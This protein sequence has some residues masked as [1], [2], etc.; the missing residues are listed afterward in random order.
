[1]ELLPVFNSI[2]RNI[3]IN[4]LKRKIRDRRL[5][6][7]LSKMYKVR[8]LTIFGFVKEFEGIFQDNVLSPILS[9]IYFNELDWFITNKIIHRYNK[10]LK[11]RIN[12]DYT[13][14]ITLTTQEKKLS[15]FERTR[16][17]AF[18]RRE[19]HKKGLRYKLIDDSFIR[20]KF[21]RYAD[22]LLVGIRGPK[23]LALTIKKTIRF[24]LKSELQLSINENNL[25]L[26]DSYATKI[27]FLG[28]TIHNI[29]TKI[30]T[31]RN[32][33]EL[34][35]IKRSRSRVLTRINVFNIRRE[36]LFRERILLNLR[37]NY[38]VAQDCGNLKRYEMELLAGFSIFLPKDLVKLTDR[39]LYRMMIQKFLK[40]T[41][42]QNN[43]KLQKFLKLW[44]NELKG[45][46]D[47][48][49]GMSSLVKKKELICLT[50]KVFVERMA[51]FLTKH[52]F[53][54]KVIK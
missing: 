36:K 41:N 28:M 15:S 29:V 6:D 34:E 48:E 47:L 25:S 45:S 27:P 9:N 2:N 7:M 17:R 42:I 3:L 51:K 30:S 33:R 44:D 19:A 31:Y 26:F 1:M 4:I 16:L 22:D 12:P 20:V 14:A 43:E 39:H 13:K 37:R 18:K 8:L 24:F 11:P 40:I 5:F 21:V 35:M 32:S 38:K 54:T 10:G 50:K 53:P 49:N 46:V 23:R 52:N